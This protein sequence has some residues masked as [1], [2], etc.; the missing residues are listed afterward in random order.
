LRYNSD[1]ELGKAVFKAFAYRGTAY[2]KNVGGHVSQLET[3]TLEDI[4]S[5]YKTHFG[6]NNLIVGIS[7]N[8]TEEVKK[9]I[10]K[11]FSQ[12]PEVTIKRDEVKPP[13]FKGLQVEIVEKKGDAT[14]IH[15][16]FPISLM[17]KDTDFH[18]LFLISKTSPMVAGVNS[19]R[20]IFTRTRNY[21]K[22]G[23]DR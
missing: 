23:F 18:A 3:I 10:D 6:R 19:H 12:L 7:G 17:R 8:F 11:D 13:P 1:E 21:L 4:K 2:E 5:F 14:G 22:S 9:N 15:I 16:G 20:P